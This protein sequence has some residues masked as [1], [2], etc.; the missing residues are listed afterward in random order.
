M[1]SALLVRVNNRCK[2]YRLS[3]EWV[4]ATCE[5]ILT[6]L[7]WKK[8]ELG[9]TLLEDAEM[10]KY[11]WKYLRHKGTTDVIS[12]S[13]IEGKKIQTGAMIPLGDIVVSLQT[14]KAKAAE[15]GHSFQ[16]E[17]AFYFCH[18]ILHLMGY[19]DKTQRQSARMDK[20]QK[21]ILK[22]IKLDPEK[23]KSKRKSYGDKKN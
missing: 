4:R 17:A 20:I 14:A 11:N 1:S 5:K 23:I 10:A 19:D 2:K 9:V 22:K 3:S 18:G 8:A 21:E 13:Q 7:S 15:L 6:A 16:Y 12:F